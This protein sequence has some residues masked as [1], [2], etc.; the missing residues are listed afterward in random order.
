MPKINVSKDLI[1]HGREFRNALASRKF[2]ATDD[3]LLFP[4]QKV[5]AQG[6][7]I[8]DVNGLD[9]REDSNLVMPEGMDHILN[10]TLRGG[11]PEAGW[12]IALFGGNVTPQPT[13]TAANFATVSSEI[14]STTQGYS[15]TTRRP[16][17][18]TAA[19]AGAITNG[20][21]K[22]GFTI[23]AASTLTVYGGALLSSNVRGGAAGIL[24]SAT[25]FSSVRTLDNGDLFN[26]AYSLTLTST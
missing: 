17:T 3:G 19:A 2:E 25:R 21:A 22:A 26:I 13:W 5:L 1:K 4:A 14:V 16:F 20:T 11:M 7:Y 18:P 6:V 15:E 24:M 8:H 23:A 12:Y 9:V 10:L